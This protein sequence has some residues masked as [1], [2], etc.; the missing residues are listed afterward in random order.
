[1][2]ARSKPHKQCP[3]SAAVRIG[4]VRS[5]QESL[6][7]SLYI[8][9]LLPGRRACSWVVPS[10]AASSN[11]FQKFQTLTG[12]ADCCQGVFAQFRAGT[13]NDQWETARVDLAVGPDCRYVVPYWGSVETGPGEEVPFLIFWREMFSRRFYVSGPFLPQDPNNGNN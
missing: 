12:Q 2:G 4:C 6:S 3:C 1:M 7:F 5:G 10:Y 8:V 13:A 11:N 9:S